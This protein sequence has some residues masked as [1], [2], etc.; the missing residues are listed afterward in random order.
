MPLTPIEIDTE[1]VTQESVDEQ[2]SDNAFI[3]LKSWRA[4]NKDRLTIGTLNSIP[5]KIDDLRTLISD[6]LDI[7]VVEETK[8]DDTFSD[9]SIKIS[10]FKHKPFR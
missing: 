2:N 9:E 10:G 8:I 7:L 3:A 1:N 4:K 6:N 5:N